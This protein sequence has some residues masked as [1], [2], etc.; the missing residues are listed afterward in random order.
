MWATAQKLY[1]PV[2]SRIGLDTIQAGVNSMGTVGGNLYICKNFMSPI[3][4]DEDIGIC[5]HPRDSAD[6]V[7]ILTVSVLML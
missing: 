4:F 7:A 3:H 2:T 1:P 6:H 5:C